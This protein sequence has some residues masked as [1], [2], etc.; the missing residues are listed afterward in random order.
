[1]YVDERLT[2]DQIAARLGCTATT[3]RRRLRALHVAI[4]PRGPQVS[5][6]LVAPGTRWTPQLAY[7]VGLIA[8]DGNLSKDGRHLTLS[9]IDRPLIESA[10]RC[11]GRDRIFYDWLCA[12]GLR[13]AK[14]LTLGPVRVPDAYFADFLRGCIDGD[15][16]ILRYTDRSQVSTNRRYVYER[17]YVNLVSASRP[18]LEWIRDTVARLVGARGAISAARKPP[19]SVWY[20]LRW[21]K[22][23]SRRVLRTMYYA[24]DVPRPARKR[25]KAAP[26]LFD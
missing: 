10:R 16:T 1:L 8:T 4:R 7:A 2:T 25:D 17:L 21:A 22:R 13:P 5:P 14:S 24:A 18:F 6:G 15:G 23:A 26:F 19:G 11:L 9:S 12:I 3:V 20:V